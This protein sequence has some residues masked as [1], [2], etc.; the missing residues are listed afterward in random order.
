M[1]QYIYIYGS[2]LLTVSCMHIK[3]IK[4]LL[5][6]IGRPFVQLDV[7]PFIVSS[8]NTTWLCL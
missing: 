3:I 1:Q 4:R 7:M 8:L 2:Y 6:T 5:N